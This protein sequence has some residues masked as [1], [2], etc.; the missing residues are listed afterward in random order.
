MINTLHYYG[1]G[2]GINLAKIDTMQQYKITGIH[3]L[4][5]HIH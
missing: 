1:E 4:C 2:M 3:A 5:S